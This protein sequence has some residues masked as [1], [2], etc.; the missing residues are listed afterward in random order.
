MIVDILGNARRYLPLHNGFAA[1]FAFLGRS[2]IAELPLGTHGIEGRNVFAI[3]A[4]EEGRRQEDALLET[5]EKYIDIQLVLAGV[6]TMGWRPKAQ[7][8]NAAGPYDPQ[9]DLQFFSDRPECWIAVHSGSFALFFPDD[10]H[11]PLIS[12]TPIHK[13][14][15]KVALNQG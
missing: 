13:V 12:A 3:I 9:A 2:D 11:M 10:A 5:H 15:V 4:R 7:C 6:D 1:A 8:Q 14:V